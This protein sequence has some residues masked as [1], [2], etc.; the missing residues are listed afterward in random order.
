MVLSRLGKCT[1]WILS[2]AGL[3]IYSRFP[4]FGRLRVAL[5]VIRNQD[6]ILAIE[7]SDGRGVSFPGGIAMPW[8]DIEKAAHREIL[9]ETGLRVTHSVLKMHYLDSVEVPVDLSVFEVEAD[10]ELRASWEG[11]PRWLDL[12]ELRQRVLPSQ[13]RIVDTLGQP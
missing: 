4:I 13:R 11:T 3:A 2:R 7:R 1:F 12:N 8:E 5:G 10:G 9:E 6:R